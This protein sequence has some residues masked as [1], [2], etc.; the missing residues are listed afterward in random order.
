MTVRRHN[1][2]PMHTLGKLFF[3][4]LAAILP[5]AL[6]GYLIYAAVV[7]GETMLRGALVWLFEE[8]KLEWH[9]WP[10][11]G[12]AVS[13][14][15]VTAAGLL[16]YSFLLRTVY[17]AFTSLLQRIPV[18]KSVYGMIVDVVQLLSAE[19]RPFHKVVLVQMQNGAEQLGF[20][21]REDFAD[22]PGFDPD[23]VAVYLPMSYQ[24]GGFTVI[25]P[26]SRIREVPMKAEDALRFCVTAGVSRSQ[27]K[28]D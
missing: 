27:P 22:L 10:G 12:F 14:V 25:V 7:A 23:R 3:R 17:R 4:G 24:L 21:T 8:F 11:M 13:I 6:T 16:T 18:V 15:L 26:R 20:L 2:A 28:N 5:V 19:D 9:Y 1:A